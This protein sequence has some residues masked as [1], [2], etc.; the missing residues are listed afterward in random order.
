MVSRGMRL[1]EGVRTGR[2]TGEGG[3]SSGIRKVGT[4]FPKKKEH[5][6]GMV[7]QGKPRKNV[8]QQRQVAAIAPAVNASPNMGIAPQFQQTQ[9]P[10]QQAQQFN[11]QNRAPRV[12]QFDPIPMTYTELYPALIE[13]SLVQ[14]RSPP[15]VPEKLPWWYKA[16]VSCSFH[17][18]A[19]SHDLEHCIALKAEVQRL[20]KSNLLSFRNTNP[21]VQANPL[22]SHS[23]HTVSLILRNT[24][25][26]LVTD[27]NLIKGN[28]VHLHDTYSTMGAFTKHDY[29]ACNICFK[30]LQGCPT[31]REDIQR[32]LDIGD[33]QIY[34]NKDDYDVNTVGHFPH[35]L[36]VSDINSE[37]PEVNVVIPCFNMPKHVEIEYKG[38]NIPEIPLVICLPGPVSYSSTKAI[39]YQYNATLIKDWKEKPMPTLPANV[40]ITEIGRVTR[41]GRIHAPL[42]PKPPVV[43]VI[44]QNPVNISPENPTTIP[45]VNPSTNVGPPD[46]TNVNTDF[47]EILKLNKKTEYRG[48]DQLMQTPSK[49]SILSLLLN[50][51]AH[52][53]ALM[54]VLDQ[55]YVDHDLTTDHFGGIV[56]NITACNNLSFSDEE[57]PEE[58]KDHNLALHISMICQSD[59]LSNVLVD[60]GSSL[61]VM[62]KTTLARLAYKG[63]P[64]KF[65][66]I[67]VRAF[68]GSRKSVIGEVDLPMTIGPQTF[69]I[70]FQVMD[71]P[72]AYSCLL[73]RPWIHEAG[74]VTSI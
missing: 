68:D 50:S 32:L 34:R 28:L 64:M 72:S 66:D 2:L 8:S 6:I 65:N 13:R 21:N 52:R 54:K 45:A 56:G 51:E 42:L 49:I 33:L 9:Q 60:T 10:R 41:S 43:P 37:N 4:S 63:T 24:D 20:V 26:Y 11:N 30:N 19:P 23:G 5:D 29:A 15:P 67:V 55:A 3:S 39:P 48:G 16:D 17:Q 7:S 22:P 69:Q 70:T 44:R 58:G 46:R 31:I 62:P 25:R 59:S 14:T 1:E 27:V 47:D 61:N 38:S 40:N 12:S 36:F 57:L 74:A 53:E 73:G 35:E 71:V 18:G